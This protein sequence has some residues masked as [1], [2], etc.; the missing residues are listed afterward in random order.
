MPLMAKGITEWNGDSEMCS[1]RLHF[2]D[3]ILPATLKANSFFY[4][5]LFRNLKSLVKP[6][7]FGPSCE[8]NSP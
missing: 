2:G 8:E 1:H 4:G 5:A 6:D 3:C 7:R